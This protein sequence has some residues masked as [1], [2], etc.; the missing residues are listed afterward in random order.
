DGLPVP[1][2]RAAPRPGRL[3]PRH[4]ARRGA[5]NADRGRVHRAEHRR[6]P[7]RRAARA[8]AENGAVTVAGET[9][10]APARR[11]P[12]RL[13]RSPAGQ[14]GLVLLGLLLLLA[15]VGPAFAPHSSSQTIDA[16]FVGPGGHALLG[17]DFLGRDVLSRVL[18]G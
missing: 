8:E 5:R 12:V 17:T 14:V 7:A 2:H 9:I 6:R 16:P 1:R 13:T 18:D 15:L 3:G 10:V 11:R 4:P